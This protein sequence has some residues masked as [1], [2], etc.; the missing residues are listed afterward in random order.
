MAFIDYYKIM[1][2][3]RD[4]PQNK[5]KAAY[6]KR[7]QMF[8]PDL[9]K[10]DPKAKVKFQMLNEAN[11]VLSDP[12][13]RKLYDQYGEHWEEAS[14][15]GFAGAG[16]G[17]YGGGSPFGGGNPFGGGGFEDIFANFFGGGHGFHAQPEDLTMRAQVDIDL[18]TALLGG[19]VMIQTADGKIKLKVHP[20]TPNGKQV[21]LSG[22]GRLGRN[23]QRGDM[24]L[25]YNVVL[26]THLTERQKE[27][28]REM[29][30][31]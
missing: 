17:S 24:I 14:R 7:A 22:K 13:K 25:T 2:V 1:G 23:G 4:Y 19:E 26:P 29:R 16:G 6:R 21:K 12:E 10:D 27:L 28:L 8:H 5:M 3:P 9:H 31:A 11:R 20:E 30:T 18:Y 15:S